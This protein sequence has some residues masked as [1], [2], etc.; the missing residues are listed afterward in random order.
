MAG[1]GLHAYEYDGDAHAGPP[2]VL[3]QAQRAQC[4]DSATL[5]RIGRPQRLLGESPSSSC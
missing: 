1:R 4:L 5:H 2:E 3:L